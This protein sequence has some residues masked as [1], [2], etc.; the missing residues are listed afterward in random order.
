M[1]DRTAAGK[2]DYRSLAVTLA[3]A[4]V[5]FS[6]AVILINSSLQAYANYQYQQKV[7]V[8]EQQLIAKGAAES[9]RNFIEEKQG[10]LETSV[11]LGNLADAESDQAFALTRIMR[12]DPAFRQ[13]ILLDAECGE[14]ASI[15]RQARM[16]PGERVAQYREDILSLGNRNARYISPVYIDQASGEPMVLLAVPVTDVFGDFQGVLAAEVN[17]K[18]MWDL[19][20]SLKIGEEGKAYV[21]D[22]E[23]NLIACGDTSRVL[24]G[25]NVLSL[26]EVRQFVGTKGG[27]P[28]HDAGVSLGIN[29]AEVV[30]NYMPLG[31]PDWAVVVEQPSGEAYRHIAEGSTR[32]FLIVLVSILLAIVTGTLLS[33]RIT[34]PLI[35]LRDATREISGGNL[36]TR[37][38]IRS[39]NEIGELAASFNTMTEDLQRTT[40]SKEYMDNIVTSMFD[41]LVVLHPD[42]AIR[43]VNRS[44][45]DGL[46][47]RRDEL[48]GRHFSSLLAPQDVQA[49]SAVIEDI[50]RTATFRET[51]LA[52]ATKDGRDIPVMFSASV[53]R[54]QGGAVQGIVCV[55]HDITRR[56]QAEEALK[57]AHDTL[58]RRVEERTA[59]LTRVNRE[60]EAEI[61]ER[62][63]VEEEIVRKSDELGAAYEE[64]AATEEELRSHFNELTRSEEALAQ[65]RNK[66]NVLNTITF[67]DIQNAV[68]TLAGYL[69]LEKDRRDDEEHLRFIETQEKIVEKVNES[70]KFASRYQNLGLSS[71]LWQDV[72]QAFLIGISHLDLSKISRSADIEGL[73]IYADPQLENVFFTLA[74]NV[75]LHGKNATEIALSFSK[76]PEGVIIIF[77]DNGVGI[78]REQKGAI[79]QRRYEDRKGL[80]LFLA[81]EILGITGI[82]IRETGEP[83]RG[84]WFEM[85]VPEG[86]YRFRRET[87]DKTPQ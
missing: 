19:V 23:G 21:V 14:L 74:E 71:P 36:D 84:A 80:G 73:A 68:F 11:S 46:G 22:G 85:I 43:S 6:L 40:V 49:G 47:Y 53:M 72:G 48:V 78:P 9:V 60:L 15:S 32:T 75:L 58:E 79:F 3:I 81:R 87:G 12:L 16:T 13:V 33:R 4:F 28:V 20:G 86:A 65:A 42:S 8:D 64:L 77:K 1:P 57:A 52:F 62:K 66:L 76:T 59:E 10:I 27:A 67:Q 18:F 54:D 25:E 29:G 82:R 5:V 51:E 41:M 34:R 44:T 83:G 24:K 63:R 26:Q 70:L 37:V 56:K 61:A 31:T 45:C 38:E 55:A 35:A 39:D 50:T 2:N 30:A 17:L 69:A 7:I